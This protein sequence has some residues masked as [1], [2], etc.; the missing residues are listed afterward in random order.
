MK[1]VM[2]CNIIIKVAFS[3]CVTIA[4]ISFENAGLLWWFVLLP[5]LGF[6]YTKKSVYDNNET[7]G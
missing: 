4:A 2:I 6:S 5:F 1:W 3:V 7:A